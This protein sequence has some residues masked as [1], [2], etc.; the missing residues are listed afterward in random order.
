MTQGPGE[1]SRSAA[2]PEDPQDRP[3]EGDLRTDY[4]RALHDLDRGLVEAGEDVAALARPIAEVDE[5]LTQRHVSEAEAAADEVRAQ[6]RQ[7]EDDAFVLIAKQAP[8]GADLR[9]IVASVRAL[10]DVVR[11][12][13][14]AVHSIRSIKACDANGQGQARQLAPMRSLAVEVF[15]A[16]VV[17]W[18]D[19]DALAVHELR[20]LDRGV[21]VARDRVW[22][23]VGQGSGQ[24]A[25]VP[26]VL[27]GRYLERYADHGVALAAHVSWAV[28][29][30]RIQDLLGGG[31]Q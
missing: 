31:D 3:W 2:L 15:E 12:G 19:R 11:A 23:D 28:T 1:R 26:L 20:G 9:E 8:V 4:R 21:T 7:L 27:L 16:G 25:T 14:L 24:G 17:A 13:R 5:P 22:E 6:V 10:Y 30:D 29:G 18:K